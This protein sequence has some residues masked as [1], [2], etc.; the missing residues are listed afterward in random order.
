MSEY[1]CLAEVIREGF[2]EEVT[3]EGQGRLKKTIVKDFLFYSFTRG[4]G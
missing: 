2:L 3:L 1:S 4:L